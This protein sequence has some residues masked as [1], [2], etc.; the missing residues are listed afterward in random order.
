MEA[1]AERTVRHHQAQVYRYLR[2]RTGSA[3][4]AEELTQEVFAD[5]A[6]ALARLPSPPTEMLAWLYTIA[7]RRFIDQ[8][9]RKQRR[10]I[11]VP[12]E[13]V[14]EALPALEHHPGT[15]NALRAAFLR[16]P[17]P[18]RQAVQLKLF[19]GR[20]FS[21][22][23]DRLGTTQAAAKMRFARGLRGLRADLEQQGIGP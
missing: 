19:E 18:Q 15:L 8:A 9:R 14:A 12:L 1:L 7:Q 2:R 22:I 21:E 16:L 17:E 3:D 20:S 4:Q 13:E 6:A 23:A 10:A 11:M 5:A